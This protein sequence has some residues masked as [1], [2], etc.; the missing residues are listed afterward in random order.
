MSGTAEN[1]P[2]DWGPFGRPIFEDL[3]ARALSR[4]GVIDVG[5]NSVRIVVFD[6]AARSPAYFYNEKILCGLG[7]GLASTGYLNAKGRERA[8]AALRRFAVIADAMGISPVTPVA[9][10]AVREAVDGPEFQAEV[11]R[12]TGLKLWIIDGREEARLSAQGVLLGWP[13]AEGLVCDIG[14]SSMELAVIGNG[15]IGKRV[16][17]PLGSFR[18]QQVE[19]GA[20]ARQKHIIGIIRDLKEQIGQRH[21]R[22]YLVG[23]LWR[24]IARLDMERRSYP[25]TVLHEYCMSPQ[26][27]LDTV[28][29]IAGND[30]SDLRASTGTS[31]ERMELVPLGSEVLA[32]LVKILRPKEIDISSYGIREGLLYEH[33]PQ[34]LRARPADR[35]LP[36]LRG[37][38]RPDARFR[39]KAF[40]LH[41]AAV[42]ESPAGAAAH[43]KGRV[44]A[45]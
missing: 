21:N 16:T 17:S 22:L 31:S 20:A 6:G 25:L 3:S 24:A 11:L 45:A 5:S 38:E 18:L 8:L 37:D 42:Q 34:R 39:Q 7:Q 30:L 2:D 41:P 44:S 36:L 23:G 19:G 29:W 14:G 9:T 1:A 40:H 33:M 32:Q 27:V 10:A 26:S 13:E 12:E 4:I 28:D 35:K 43:H 15:R